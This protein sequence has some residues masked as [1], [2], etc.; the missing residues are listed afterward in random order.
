MSYGRIGRA[1]RPA[2]AGRPRRA[3]GPGPGGGARVHLPPRRRSGWAA[4]PG[5]TARRL[6]ARVGRALPALPR[7]GPARRGAG[8]GVVVT[9]RFAYNTNGLS[10]HRLDDALP[11]LADP[12]YA[13]VALTLDVQHLDPFAPDA[14]RSRPSACAA[15]CDELGLGVVVETGA[16]FLLD[17]RDKHEPTLVTASEEGRARRLDFL[18]RCCDVAEVLQAEAVSFWTGVPRAGVDRR[19]GVALGARR[20]RRARRQ[21]R[22]PRLRA[23]RRAR[24]GHARRR[25]RRLAAAAG[26]GAAGRAGPRH[27]AL[28]RLRPVRARQAPSASSRRTS[29]RSRSRACAAACTSTCRWTRA[30]STCRR[31]SRAL[32]DVGYDRLVTLELSRDSHRAHELVPRALAHLRSGEP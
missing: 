27:R 30:T 6:D 23:R 7:A 19:A 14:A 22:R 11:L 17:P 2:A 5:W 13:G 1:R 24:A 32:D 12:G 20:R 26:V 15:R 9:L 8:A 29:A 10:P 25:L 28:R 18:R 21:P 31:S 4:R 16:R 3:V